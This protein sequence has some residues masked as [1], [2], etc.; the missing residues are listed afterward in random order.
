VDFSGVDV[1]WWK[2][3]PTPI[4]I[5]AWNDED[6]FLAG[7]DHG[8]QVGTMHVADPHTVPGK[9]FFEWGPGNEGR[10]W[11]GILTDSDGPYLEL[12]V[13]GYSDNQ[14]DY[15]WIAPNET[16]TLTQ[17]WYPHPR[18]RRRDGRHAGGRRQPGRAEPGRVRLA[19]NATAFH[20]RARVRLTRGD[21]MVFDETVAIGPAA[22]YSRVV[23]VPPGTELTELRASLVDAGG[24]ELV[25]YQ[26]R[27]GEGRARSRRR[28]CRPRHRATW[29]AATSCISPACASSSSTAPPRNRSPITRRRSAGRR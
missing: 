3:H 17:T 29:R 23:P 10:F 11:D 21:A 25:A 18:P 22:P 24:R 8:R 1:S 28:S 4:S 16:K 12:M 2:N 19:F 27:A 14:P 5:F 26:P 13:G 6:R 9:K 15:S 7:Y 20:P